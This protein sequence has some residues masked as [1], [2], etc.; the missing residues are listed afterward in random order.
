MKKSNVSVINATSTLSKPSIFFEGQLS[1]V[2]RT[3][4]CCVLLSPLTLVQAEI[5]SNYKDNGDGTVTDKRTNLMW[6]RC[7]AGT[8][9]WDGTTC[10][11]DA[12]KLGYYSSDALE[13]TSD[14]AGH[15]DWYLPSI[16]EL[17]SSLPYQNALFPN[18]P[19][20]LKFWSSTDSRNGSMFDHE[21]LQVISFGDDTHPTQISIG[22]KYAGATLKG[23]VNSFRLVRKN[24]GGSNPP[25]VTPIEEFNPA[26]GE[27][28]LP[29]VKYGKDKYS[30]VLIHEGDFVFRLKSATKK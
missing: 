17:N 26:T 19:Y 25:A 12:S 18:Q 14:F 8:Q 23:S 27:L 15:T 20:T 3:L 5:D 11:G 10:V 24:Q 9:T 13:F 22:S 16:D 1:A 6:M 2:F 7:A 21:Y 30:A 28:T 29:D 4:L